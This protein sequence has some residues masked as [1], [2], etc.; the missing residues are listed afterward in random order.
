MSSSPT[1]ASF[2][3]AT[4]SLLSA[5]GALVDPRGRRGRRYALVPIVAAAIAATLAGASSFTAIAAWLAD[6]D[7]A[8][9]VALGLDERRRTP[10]ESVF[11]R[12]LARLD[13]EL[14]D[15][16]IGAW[17]W[18]TT[19]VSD[20]RRVIA[21]DGKTVRGA[22][23]A[24]ATAPHLVAAFDHTACVVLAQLAVA[25]KTNEIPTVRTLLAALDLRGA[26]LT[27]D[28]MHTQDDTATLITNAGGDYVFTVKDNRPKLRAAL[29]A[30]PW[31]DVPAHTYTQRTKGRRVTRTIKVAAVPAWITFPGAAQVA[32]LRRTVKIKGKTTV[33]VIY[34]ITSADTTPA[35]LATWVQ[36]HWAIEN[37]LHYVR[38]VAY[39]EDASR[40]RTGHAPQTMATLR[41]TAI[42][43]H[44]LNGTL[45]ITAALRHHERRPDKI[46]TL[47]TCTDRTLP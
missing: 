8:T 41:S 25:A 44:R 37:K 7:R 23:T 47:L 26:V 3:A 21:I 28:A 12:L 14:L 6:Q 1:V 38:D 15:T 17:M 11:R 35:T 46:I 29:K 43:L 40:I 16:V 5:L 42:S 22:R 36:G 9:A 24:G 32:Q 30:L 20:G 18:T 31:K 10:N 13:P 2:V 34:V 27:I 45:N 33:E 39:A 19:R 4:P